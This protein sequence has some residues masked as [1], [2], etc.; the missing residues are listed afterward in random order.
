MKENY[1]HLIETFLKDDTLDTVG[2][3]KSNWRFKVYPAPRI[4]ITKETLQFKSVNNKINRIKYGKK[5]GK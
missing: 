2:K 3:P 4:W 1:E 5:E